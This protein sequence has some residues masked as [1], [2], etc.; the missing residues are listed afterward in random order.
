MVAAEND[1][2]VALVVSVTRDLTARVHAGRVVKEIAPVV[3]GT[4][5]GRPD[6]AQAGGRRPDRIA[7]LFPE[8]QAVVRRMLGAPAD[9]EA[10]GTGSPGA[11]VPAS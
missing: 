1:G 8:C 3:G 7:D 5:G 6:F 10:P 9:A 4:G 2:K 11:R